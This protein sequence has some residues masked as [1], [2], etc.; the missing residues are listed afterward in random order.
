MKGLFIRLFG[1][2]LLVMVT[3]SG[4]AILRLEPHMS[5]VTQGE[6]VSLDLVIS[7]LGNDAVGAFDLSIG[8]DSTALSF[9]NYT[10]GNGLGDLSFFEA[11]D[12]S[13]GEY[14]TGNIGLTEVSLLLPWELE[15]L[16]SANFTLATLEFSVDS[17]V[18]GE[19]SLVSIDEVWALGDAYGNPLNLNATLDA[20]IKNV[21]EPSALLILSLG[22]AGIRFS[23]WRFTA[24]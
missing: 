19:S 16:Q 12:F 3:Q 10:L 17:L 15:S 9:Q 13:M 14:A 8:Y 11:V 2:I 21:P 4:A 22:L 18:K 7:G 24:G 6:A 5:I 23:R 1:L 20:V